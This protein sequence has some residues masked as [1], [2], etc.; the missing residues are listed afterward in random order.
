MLYH[1]SR[2]RSHLH[3]P[4]RCHSQS[5]GSGLKLTVFIFDSYCVAAL[6]DFFAMVNRKTESNLWRNLDF[7]IQLRRNA[8]AKLTEPARIRREFELREY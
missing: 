6:L 5:K 3:D 4:D 2:F 8:G 7:K 1:Y